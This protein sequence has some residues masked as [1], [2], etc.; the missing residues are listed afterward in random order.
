MAH[1]FRRRFDLRQRFRH[2]VVQAEAGELGIQPTRG[3]IDDSLMNAPELRRQRL[4]LGLV[5]AFGA[6]PFPIQTG[7]ID[8]QQ[9]R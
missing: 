3:F 6:D 9:W 1:L 5:Y 7:S 8:V 2:A 4:D